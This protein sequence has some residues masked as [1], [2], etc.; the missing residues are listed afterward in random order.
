MVYRYGSLACPTCP[1]W[2]GARHPDSIC[3]TVPTLYI[4]T[5][6]AKPYRSN[7]VY[8][9]AVQ[10][11]HHVLAHANPGLVA[12]CIRPNHRQNPYSAGEWL[13]PHVSRLVTR[14]RGALQQCTEHAPRTNPPGGT[15]WVRHGQCAPSPS[16]P[17]F[18]V[19]PLLSDTGTH[20]FPY[21]KSLLLLVSCRV[22]VS[23]RETQKKKNGKNVSES[24]HR[25]S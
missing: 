24:K 20:A 23:C 3:R 19:L 11:H 1:R 16:P 4:S 14:S 25:H 2:L 12:I 5:Y 10:L 15:P 9:T 7:T 8:L 13:R 18:N 17:I 6:C 22:L 21:R